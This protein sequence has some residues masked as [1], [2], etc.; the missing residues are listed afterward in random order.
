LGIRQVSLGQFVNSGAPIVTLEALD[1]IF[2]DFALPQ[3]RISDITVGEE[4]HVTTDGAGGQAFT[5][6]V[7]AIDPRVDPA[8][9]NVRVRATLSNAEEKLRSGMFASVELVLPTAAPVIV[10][11]SS[12]VLYAPYGNSVFV[13]VRKKND[14]G[15][16]QTTVRQQTVRLGVTRGDFVTVVSGVEPGDE[17]VST[18]AFKL[19]N[20]SSVFINNDIVVPAELAPKPANS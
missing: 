17:V 2:V 16:E 6:K 7:T 5:G 10:I 8:T 11:P 9:R 19:R 3:Q 1:P 18:G 13:I 20:G 15:A 14:K 12:S 4:V